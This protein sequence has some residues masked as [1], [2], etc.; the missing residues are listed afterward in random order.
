MDKLAIAVGVAETS[1][2]TRGF[3]KLYNNC[4]GLK[5]GNTAPCERVGRN[6][7]CIYDT[8]QESLEAFKIVWVKWYRRFPDKRLANKYSGKDRADTWLANVTTKYNSL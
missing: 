5:N 7:M 6:R 8:P 4:V 2:C 1:G 3:G